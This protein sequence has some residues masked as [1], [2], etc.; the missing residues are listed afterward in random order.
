MKIVL[1]NSNMVFRSMQIP[2]AIQPA[3]TAYGNISSEK[4]GALISLYNALSTAGFWNRITELYLPIIANTVA[5]SFVNAKDGVVDMTPDSTQ[6]EI[7][8]QGIK[9]V[10]ESAQT[11]G[12]STAKT[13]NYSIVDKSFLAVCG[14]VASGHEKTFP[15]TPA[16]V[17]EGTISNSIKLYRE[18][19]LDCNINVWSG[20]AVPARLTT[21]TD[22]SNTLF[23]LV[24]EDSSNYWEAN[25]ESTHDDTLA[26][27][28]TFSGRTINALYPI[29]DT[30][31]KCAAP[32]QMVLIMDALTK[33]E[34]ASL[35]T[36]CYNFVDSLIS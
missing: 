16:T 10:V 36:I 18:Y 25:G 28:K 14:K 30:S 33:Q 27:T 2:E 11:G 22:R 19:G 26:S 1:Q 4:K 24:I 6:A 7:T 29:G 32:V 12:S 23:G 8:S 13:V 31:V 20:L 34:Y 5:T 17:S 9:G 35:R 3:L 21:T 15:I